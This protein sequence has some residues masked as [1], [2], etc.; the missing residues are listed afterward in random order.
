MGTQPQAEEWMHRGNTY[1]NWEVRVN[2]AC[3]RNRKEPGE[4][5]AQGLS[6]FQ[7]G[8]KTKRARLHEPHRRLDF[9]QSHW[10]GSKHTD[11]IVNIIKKI[12]GWGGWH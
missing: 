3:S 9:I 5:G 12:M 10:K 6:D 11:Q 4:A 2:L 7:Q 8:R 1:K